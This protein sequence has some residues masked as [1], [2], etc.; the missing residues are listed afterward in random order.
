ML[1]TRHL[2]AQ[3][4]LGAGLQALHNLYFSFC[5]FHP[6]ASGCAPGVLCAQLNGHA[7]MHT[8]RGKRLTK[9]NFILIGICSRKFNVPASDNFSIN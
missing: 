2:H 6:Q 1:F 8:G 4:L 5:R 9:F 7:Q 3:Q